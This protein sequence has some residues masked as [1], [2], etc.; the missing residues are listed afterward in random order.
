MVRHARCSGEDADP[1]LVG[2]APLAVFSDLLYLL[3]LGVQAFFT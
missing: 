1:A 3:A 2:A